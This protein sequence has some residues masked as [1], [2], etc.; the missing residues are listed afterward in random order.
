MP[1]G[2][3]GRQQADLDIAPS[4]DGCRKPW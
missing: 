1:T 2:V 4:G 3:A